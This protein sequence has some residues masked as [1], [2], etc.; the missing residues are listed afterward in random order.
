[1]RRATKQLCADEGGGAL[2]EVTVMLSIIFIFVMGSVDF[3]M[4][5]YQWNAATKAV[6]VGARIAAVSDSVATGFTGVT[7]MEG[8]LTPGQPTPAGTYTT[9]TCSGASGGSCTGGGTYNSAA[10]NT[11]VFGRKTNGCTPTSSP[12]CIGM[13]DVFWRI[14]PA[15][16]SISYVSSGLGYAARPGGPVPTITVSIQ[17]LPFQFFFLGHLLGSVQIPGLTTTITGEDLCSGPPPAPPVTA[18]PT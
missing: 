16:V 12:Y 11:I 4:A 5:M 6:E 1:M 9:R 7:G 17:N 8:G 13:H 14:Q 10:M 15:N 3:L 18:C 2:V